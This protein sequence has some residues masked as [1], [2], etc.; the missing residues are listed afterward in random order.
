MLTEEQFQHAEY[1]IE[2]MRPLDSEIRGGFYPKTAPL[3]SVNEYFAFPNATMWCNVYPQPE[4]IV[5]VDFWGELQNHRDV[6]A[7]LFWL[8][9]ID[10]S[11][12]SE[13]EMLADV[14]AG[15]GEIYSD[16]GVLITTAAVEEVANWFASVAEPDQLEE[17]ADAPDLFDGLG[18]R[19]I[20]PEGTRVVYFWYD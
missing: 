4:N 7:L 1:L 3:V 9:H 13:S 12:S 14:R 5:E 20:A 2:N 8:I 16:K 10:A 19:P 6:H 17:W 11:G 15:N 18:E